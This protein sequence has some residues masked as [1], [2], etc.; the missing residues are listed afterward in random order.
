VRIRTRLTLLLTL[1]VLAFVAVAFAIRILDVRRIRLLT[2]DRTRE[3]TALFDRLVELQGKSCKVFSSDYSYWDDMVRFV[4]T[5]DSGWARENLDSGMTAYGAS[6]A[7]VLTTDCSLVYA[8]TG[9]GNEPPPARPLPQPVCAQVFGRTWFPHFWAETE[10]GLEEI[11]GAPIQPSADAQRSTP[12]QGFFM[13]GEV[14]GPALT[15]ELSQL[16]EGD[17]RIENAP[18][19][20]DSA[21]HL[22]GR[23]SSQI[24]FRR[25]LAGW[26]GDTTAV[27]LV[28]CRSDAITESANQSNRL[29]LVVVVL[30]AVIQLLLSLALMNWVNKPL[31]LISRA[32][33]SESPDLVR[34]LEKQAH[35]FG[36]LARLIRG[37]FEQKENLATEVTVRKQA[38][39][40]LARHEHHLEELVQDR[41]RELQQ[42]QEQLVREERLAALGQ[43]AGGIAHELRNP[44]AAIRN[45]TYYLNT[46]HGRDLPE[47]GVRQLTTIEE[48]VERSNQ[49]I[50]NLLDFARG[51]SAEPEECRVEDILQ[52]AIRQAALPAGVEVV[53]H[54]PGD[55]PRVMV[56]P[57]QMVQVFLNL[58]TNASQ[59]MEASGRVTVEGRRQNEPPAAESGERIAVSVSDTG[60]GISPE[61]LARVFEPLF[62][63]KTRGTGLGLAICK[64]FVERNGGNISAESEPGKGATF[65]V[66]LPVTRAKEELR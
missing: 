5:R 41:T 48:Q 25:A 42:A 37:F 61:A 53:N 16:I 44:L 3:K 18:S 39:A 17:A 54:I 58:L 15:A 40:E 57:R 38:Q 32:L 12:P 13:V 26:N 50:T 60:P 55:L 28:Q 8:T 36:N 45:A 51:R 24:A 59:A 2:S 35:E 21:N 66:T 52:D 56:D 62:T 9:E 11:W 27:V 1:L 33:K 23:G 34:P 63:T 49:I 10:Q 6:A 31:D 65:I 22:P 19:A 47:K 7:W 46:V 4:K 29:F 43:A 14:W 30:S 20:G 64:S